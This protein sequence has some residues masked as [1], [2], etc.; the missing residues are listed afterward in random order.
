M[1][2]TLTLYD[3]LTL[4]LNDVEKLKLALTL[5]DALTLTLYDALTLTSQTISDKTH[6]WQIMYMYRASE[7][8]IS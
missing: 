3:A 1:L 7:I 5:Y 8:Y 2:D 6:C 4:T